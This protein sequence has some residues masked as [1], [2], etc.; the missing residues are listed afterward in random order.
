MITLTQGSLS[1]LLISCVLSTSVSLPVLAEGNGVIVIERAVRGHMWGRTAGSDPSPT[2]AN[3]NPSAQIYRALNNTELTDGDI[4]GIASGSGI[5]R[6]VMPGGNLPGFDNNG[7]GIGL[8]AGAAA[9][10]GG[11]SSI[12]G[13]VNGAVS[14]GLQPL[15]TIGSMVGGR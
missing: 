2:T 1:L 13:T 14:R 7:A 9:S 6:T 11:G 4:A 5:T 8:G 3:A 12:A 10:H 15:N